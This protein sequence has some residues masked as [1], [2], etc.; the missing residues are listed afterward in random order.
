MYWNVFSP[1]LPHRK[2]LTL[3][4]LLLV[5]AHANLGA[6]GR[7]V[8]ASDDDVLALG[9]PGHPAAGQHAGRRKHDALDRGARRRRPNGVDV[10]GVKQGH[11]T[12]KV[13]LG[14]AG[15]VGVA[16][17]DAQRRQRPAADA[18]SPREGLAVHGLLGGEWKSE[19]DLD[20]AAHHKADTTGE[21]GAV[22]NCVLEGAPDGLI[23]TREDVQGE[24]AHGGEIAGHDQSM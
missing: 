8:E 9:S 13:A 20:A 15:R 17:D 3:G 16:V 24:A 4:S 18:G 1:G 6:P 7:E 21:R 19:G 10:V 23:D 12:E 2:A 11:A 14:T 5:D 22:A